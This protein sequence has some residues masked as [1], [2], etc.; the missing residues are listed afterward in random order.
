M[1]D[2]EVYLTILYHL[3][4]KDAGV[5]KDAMS[6]NDL[7]KRAEAMLKEA[8]KIDCKAFVTAKDV[9]LG[10]EKLN[11]AFIANILNKETERKAQKGESVMGNIK[12]LDRQL[13]GKESKILGMVA[14]NEEGKVVESEGEVDED[15]TKVLHNIVGQA[16]KL[17]RMGR[18]Q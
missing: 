10:N 2:S 1:K 17:Q 11:F 8:E 13:S 5:T 12:G 3:A 7:N 15:V 4:P 6:I 16:S 9:S 14:M 18:T